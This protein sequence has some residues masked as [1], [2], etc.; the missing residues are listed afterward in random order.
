MRN[1][2][3]ERLTLDTSRGS[4][5]DP[6]SATLTAEGSPTR[7]LWTPGVIAALVATLPIGIVLLSMN[8]SVVYANDAARP[9][10]TNAHASSA[11]GALDNI[12]GHA[13]L[14][15]VVLRDQELTVDPC[16]PDHGCDRLHGHH[17]L[18]SATPLCRARDEMD[19]LLVIIEDVTA[20]HEMERVLPMLESLARL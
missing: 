12:I 2:P 17:L 15:Q 9:L 5:P 7:M 8:G 3:A 18:V 1:E 14:A 16:L 4:R 20:Q 6:Q 13:L 19:G 11:R 10:W